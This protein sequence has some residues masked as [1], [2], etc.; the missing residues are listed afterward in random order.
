ML[1]LGT[2]LGIEIMNLG[3]QACHDLAIIPF[4]WLGRPKQPE[5]K[6]EYCGDNPERQLK[7]KS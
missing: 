5:G 7:C 3:I 6:K 1:L 4:E 2:N